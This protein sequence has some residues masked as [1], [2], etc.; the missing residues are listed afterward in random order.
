MKTEKP[1]LPHRTLRPGALNVFNRRWVDLSFIETVRRA[2]GDVGWTEN[3]AAAVTAADLCGPDIWAAYS[4]R[5][6]PV[7]GICIAYLVATGELPLF[8]VNRKGQKPNRF[9]YRAGV[10]PAVFK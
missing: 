6:R 4:V 8:K 10:H 1:N 9:K 7:I 2:V 5:Q 3:F